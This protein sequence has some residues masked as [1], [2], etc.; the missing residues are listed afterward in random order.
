MSRCQSYG[1]AE[2]DVLSLPKPRRH[3]PIAFCLQSSSSEDEVVPKL[4]KRRESPNI[5]DSTDDSDFIPSESDLVRK[6]E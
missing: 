3:T 1:F 6:N 2:K 4:E 5:P